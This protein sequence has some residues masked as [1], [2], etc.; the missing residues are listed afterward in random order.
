VELDT[1]VQLLES[2]AT[3]AFSTGDTSDTRT[4]PDR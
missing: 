2:S 1:K 3:L 4:M